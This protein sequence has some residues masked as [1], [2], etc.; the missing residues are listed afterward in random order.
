MGR[1]GRNDPCWCGSGKKYKKCHIG[2]APPVAS[3]D[4]S[5]TGSQAGVSKKG[6]IVKGYVSPMRAVPDHIIRP[7]YAETGKPQG[8]RARTCVKTAEEIERMRRAGRVARTVLDTVLGAVKPG[9]TTDSLDI[10]AHEK[11]I[12]LGAYPSPLNYH[13]F[14]KS[15]CTSVNE[16]VCHGIPDDRVLL[17][18]DIINCDVTIFIDGM[19]GDCS[20][21]VFV[22]KPDP[23]SIKLVETTYDCLMKGIEAVRPGETLNEIG[24]AISQIAQKRGFSIVRDFAGHGIGN[25]FHQ[26]PQIVHYPDIRQRQRVEVGMTFTI[27]PMI[28]V[29]THRCLIWPDDWTAVTTDGGRSAQFEHTILVQPTG[30]EL[31]T[32]GEGDPWFKRQIAQGW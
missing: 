32:G 7:S 1:I 28:N 21:T 16:V 3:G 17:P 11:A 22:G 26:D 6:K 2:Q 31:L 29:G 5:R 20:E 30:N 23:Q 24:K 27:E 10:I 25:Q 18:G 9:I 8:A 4:A 14:P 13:N 12:E 15:L 19:H